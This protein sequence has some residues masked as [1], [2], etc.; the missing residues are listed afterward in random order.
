M[1]GVVQVVALLLKL[2]YFYDYFGVQLIRS[3]RRGSHARYPPSEL[4]DTI[5]QVTIYT[6]VR[7]GI[8]IERHPR[9]ICSDFATPSRTA[10]LHVAIQILH[11]ISALSPRFPLL[12]A[13]Q[14]GGRAG[15]AR[16]PYF[17]IF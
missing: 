5:I 2:V 1:Q 3:K 11:H 10:S 7:G 14:N 6:A 13:R 12:F 15:F 4:P 16:T 17:A 9:E 8:L